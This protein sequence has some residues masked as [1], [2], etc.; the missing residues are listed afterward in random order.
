M[1]NKRL[2]IGNVYNYKEA[3]LS[4]DYIWDNVYKILSNKYLADIKITV[5]KNKIDN[6]IIDIVTIDIHFRNI[7]LN[8][9]CI[10]DNYEIIKMRKNQEYIII[11]EIK[12]EIEKYIRNAICK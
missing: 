4:N 9:K 1:K 5:R 3:N 8:Y 12:L 6:N 11:K 2:E 10:F 7:K